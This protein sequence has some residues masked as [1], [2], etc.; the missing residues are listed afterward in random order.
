MRD[1][2]KNPIGVHPYASKNTAGAPVQVLNKIPQV[3]IPM[4]MQ[5]GP[6][7]KCMVKRGETVTV[8]QMIGEPNSPMTV[9]I[10]SSV[11]GEV[12][13]V[14]KELQSNGQECDVVV[15]KNDNRFR[16]DPELAPPV[17]ESF[18]DFIA[19]VRASGLV[20]LGGAGFPTHFKLNPPPD[21][22]IDTLLING[23]ECEPYIT[24][25]DYQARAYAEQIIR[26]IVLVLDW[27]KIP[28]AT[29][30]LES[31]TPDAAQ[32]LREAL[33]QVPHDGRITL[34]VLPA[35][36]PQGA[37]KVMILNITGRRVKSGQLPHD[38]GCLV[39]NIGTVRYV[40]E[41]LETGMPLTRRFLTLDG[42]ALNRGGI[43][44]VP[45]GALINDL[46]S[47]AGGFSKVP[48][49]IIM[50][51]PMMGMA[52]NNV[53]TSIIKMNNAIVVF[54]SV[55]SVLPPETACIHCGRCADVCPMHLM[56]T[57]L[58]RFSRS[59]DV[60]KLSMYDAMDCIECG[61]CTYICPAKRF[62]VQHIRIGKQLMREAAMKKRAE[63]AAKMKEATV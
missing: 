58:D 19:A 2:M 43:Y 40:A 55:H 10:H 52:V 17:V 15:I 9:P 11:S 51:G 35:I 7:C 38:V 57:A 54:D 63:E 31:N 36:Y 23:M 20:G 29:I 6:G 48:N 61:S 59:G 42:P 26:G 12:L 28:K 3:R 45:I 27:C 34:A 24:T 60:E 41:Y 33:E 39:M 22:P 49:K 30:G 62:I 44:D 18:D 47:L 4:N 32:A 14:V 1:Y 16:K 13:E 46:I 53:N 8:G 21:K 50:G 5:I 56:P 25:D 37:E